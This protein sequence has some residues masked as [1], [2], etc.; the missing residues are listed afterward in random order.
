LGEFDSEFKKPT[1][2]NLE[3]SIRREEGKAVGDLREDLDCG[4]GVHRFAVGEIA[5]DG[6]FRNAGP[7]RDL[8]NG[9]VIAL[10][11]KFEKCFDNCGTTAFSAH[12]AAIT[13]RF[14]CVSVAFGDQS[15]KRIERR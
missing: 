8:S 7:F 2:T 9:W 6:A 5:E 10:V 3:G 1:K 14:R 13:E 15:K 11:H 12:A 4:C